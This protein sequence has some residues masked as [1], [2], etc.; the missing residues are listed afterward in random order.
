MTSS[1][2]MNLLCKYTYLLT[3]LQMTL[4]CYF[5]HHT[6]ILD[7]E[8]RIQPSFCHDLQPYKWQ[9]HKNKIRYHFIQPHASHAQIRLQADTNKPACWHP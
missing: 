1:D 7:T 5:D 9:T 2:M 6:V 4:H 3:Y 8:R